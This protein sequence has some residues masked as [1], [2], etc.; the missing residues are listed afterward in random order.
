MNA[1]NQNYT[2]SYMP[3]PCERGTTC[4]LSGCLLNAAL[5]RPLHAQMRIHLLLGGYS[6]CERQTPIPLPS[7]SYT[8]IITSWEMTGLTMWEPVGRTPTGEPVYQAV[9]QGFENL[10]K[11]LGHN[12]GNAP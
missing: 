4:P 6:Q 10:T 9:L 11:P 3:M 8:R 1:L 7:A 12:V 5:E 2:H